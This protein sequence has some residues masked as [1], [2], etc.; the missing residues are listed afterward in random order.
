M[1][2]ICKTELYN[3][4]L[5]GDLDTFIQDIS[6]NPLKIDLLSRVKTLRLYEADTS[7]L[8]D[9]PPASLQ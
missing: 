7:L 9:L 8:K 6:S 3:D 1:Y 2:E 5:V 4:C